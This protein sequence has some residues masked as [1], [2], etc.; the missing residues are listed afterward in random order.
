VQDADNQRAMLEGFAT[1]LVP[2]R[3][4][5]FYA[6]RTPLAEAGS[7]IVADGLFEHVGRVDEYPY[8]GGANRQRKRRGGGRLG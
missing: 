3:S 5:V 2:E 8:A 7:A 1:Q 6:K 4:L